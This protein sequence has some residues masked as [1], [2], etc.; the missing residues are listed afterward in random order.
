[1]EH[2]MKY[3]LIAADVDG[4]LLD[5]SNRITEKTKDAIKLCIE[6]GV[7]FTISSGRPVQGVEKLNQILNLDSPF[8]TYNG[9][10]VIMGKSKEILYEKKMSAENA[11]SVINLGEK[12]G[13]TMLVWTDNKLYSNKINERTENYSK[14]ANIE[15]VL[16]KN[17][18]DIAVNGVSKVLW[19]DEIDKINIF[20]AEA[21]KYISNEINFHTSKPMF[22]EFVDK[23]A[24]K[25]IA[26][27]KIGEKFGIAREEMIAI[28]D[29]LN[30]LSMIEYAGLGI[31]MGNAHEILKRKAQYITSSND[32]DG[33]ANAIYK[34]ILNSDL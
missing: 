14:I 2:K 1:M 3:R 25:A 7:I 10:M 5:S 9:A 23:G 34:F 6:K 20:L 12:W 4:T 13:P 31:A 29:G 15:P 26:M 22:L 16:V 8:I 27:E 19:Y 32:Q 11:K 30:D 33:V 21:G 24:S 28:G 18:A 17:L